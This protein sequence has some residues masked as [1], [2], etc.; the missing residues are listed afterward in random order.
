M[1]DKQRHRTEY[2]KPRYFPVASATV[3]EVGDLLWWD[4]GASSVKPA[5]DFTWDTDLATTQEQFAKLFVGMSADRS[6]SGDTDDIQVDAAGVKE[7]ACAA[8]TFNIGD[9][10]G[11]DDNATP[12][13]LLSQQVIAVGTAELAI[14][15]VTKRYAS[16]TTVVCFEALPAMLSRPQDNV[17]PVFVKAHTVTAGEDAAGQVDIDTGW[18]VAIAGPVLVTIVN[19]SGAVK[20][21]DVVVTKLTGGDLGKV[22]VA[23]GTG[24]AVAATDVIH[25]AIYKQNT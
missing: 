17:N 4:A 2:H 24:T 13:A 10:V 21:G 3:I 1:A 18:G 22:R 16:N 9:M 11:P 20:T 7:F 12:D 15:R 5:A 14:G 23:D 6:A 19:S 25:I 8:A